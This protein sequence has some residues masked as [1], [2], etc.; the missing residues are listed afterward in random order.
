MKIVDTVNSDDFPVIQEKE[1]ECPLVPLIPCLAIYLNSVLAVYGL[2]NVV[3]QKFF[4]YFQLIGIFVYIAYGF[5]N[6]KL[7][8]R[9]QQKYGSG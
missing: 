8:G 9:L 4:I 6:T 7:Q 2:Q 3:M 5:H 1:F